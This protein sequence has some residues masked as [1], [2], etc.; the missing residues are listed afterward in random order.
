MMSGMQS[1]VFPVLA[2]TRDGLAFCLVFKADS[3]SCAATH[4]SK[5]A[6]I[7]WGVFSISSYCPHAVLLH[8]KNI[9]RPQFRT[10]TLHGTKLEYELVD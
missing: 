10:K 3:V 2:M 1:F 4:V 5:L 8:L 6:T 7:F 9:S